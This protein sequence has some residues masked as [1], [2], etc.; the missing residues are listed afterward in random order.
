VRTGARQ[1]LSYRA[2]ATGTY[3]VQ[4]RMSSAGLT[5]YRLAIIKA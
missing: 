3:F 1:Y 5:R 4:V 2:R